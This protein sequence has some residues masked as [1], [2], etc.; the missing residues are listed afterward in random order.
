MIPIGQM[1]FP[2]QQLQQLEKYGTFEE[3][4][5]CSLASQ[6]SKPEAAVTHNLRVHVQRPLF[7]CCL[8]PHFIIWATLSYPEAIHL[9]PPHPTDVENSNWGK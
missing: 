8:F 3:A 1:C 2:I 4:C 5:I 6:I 7:P 9:K